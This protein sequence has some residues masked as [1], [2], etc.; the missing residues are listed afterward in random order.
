MLATP[1]K[2][3]EDRFRERLDF[4]NKEMQAIIDRADLERDRLRGSASRSFP[5]D[6][7]D[8]QRTAAET[9][10]PCVPSLSSSPFVPPSPH[11]PPVSSTNE[12]LSEAAVRRIV[13]ERVNEL[14]MCFQQMFTDAV[15]DVN[16]GI[17]RRFNE[18][19]KSRM[20]FHESLREAAEAAR[21]SVSELQS[22]F[23]RLRR[24]IDRPIDELNRLLRE[25]VSRTTEEEAQLRD[26]IGALENEARIERQRGDRR[27]DELVRRHHDLVRSSLLELDAHVDGLRDELQGTIRTQTKQASE[28]LDVTQQQV[29]RLQGAVEAMNETTLRWV[30]ELRDLMEENVKARIEMQA[31]RRDVDNLT[32]LVQQGIEG[33]G[34]LKRNAGAAQG[35]GLLLNTGACDTATC[36]EPEGDV[37]A[38]RSTVERLTA[39]VSSI[40]RQVVVVDDAL[41][42]LY[43]AAGA[44]TSS[45]CVVN[46]RRIPP[47]HPDASRVGGD[48]LLR[49]SQPAHSL[50]RYGPHSSH[51]PGTPPLYGR[52]QSYPNPV[53]GQGRSGMDTAGNMRGSQCWG[54]PASSSDASPVSGFSPNG[55]QS[56][57]T[58]WDEARYHQRHYFSHHYPHHVQQG[59]Y[60]YHHHHQQQQQQRSLSNEQYDG[61]HL[62]K[63]S[64]GMNNTHGRFVDK[65]S[66]EGAVNMSVDNHYG[67][68]DNS[69]PQRASS[70]VMVD[71]TVA[72]GTDISP[73]LMPTSSC[74]VNSPPVSD[75]YTSQGNISPRDCVKGMQYRP[76]PTSDLESESDNKKMARLPL[77]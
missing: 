38:L 72:G 24:G 57:H 15:A 16:A 22:A 4:I 29:A 63:Q 62:A 39:D 26:A 68:N 36:E 56:R 41:R 34:T 76:A 66:Q 70:P 3:D 19:N 31:L 6:F 44:P 17:Q 32:I 13:D 14:R 7:L 58:G 49:S 11:H 27:V 74:K 69:V 18:V 71:T 30:S 20:D 35:G 28:D 37:R 45:G 54:I 5:P 52:M 43:G 9:L 8:G 25:H 51:G 61:D 47:L 67:H 1:L 55:P 50:P 33:R 2:N 75:S 10:P 60:H 48:N 40:G 53:A 42:R 12:G 64:S 23:N 59:H 21:G 73:T 46:D 77:D 65:R